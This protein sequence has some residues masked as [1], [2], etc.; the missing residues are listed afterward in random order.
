MAGGEDLGK[1]RQ[2]ALNRRRVEQSKGFAGLLVDL[3]VGADRDE[4]PDE[5]GAGQGHGEADLRAEANSG[6]VNGSELKVFD[7]GSEVRGDL[8]VGK[9]VLGIVRPAVAAMFER[10][11]VVPAGESRLQCRPARLSGG[12][13]RPKCA[14]QENQ[15]LS[16]PRL[17]E[18]CSDPV[19]F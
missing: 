18:V 13:E 2:V 1:L 11:R 16:D 9:V 3:V 12:V 6:D 15:R 4:G 17:L 5:V 7:D 19:D 10:D 14:V 8:G